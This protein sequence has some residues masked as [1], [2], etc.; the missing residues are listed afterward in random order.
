MPSVVDGDKVMHP[1]ESRMSGRRCWLVALAMTWLTAAL[2]EA[3]PPSN[4]TTPPSTAAPPTQGNEDEFSTRDSTVGYIDSAIPMDMFRLRF[5]AAY[6]DNHP[7]R[8]E[9][10][11]AKTGPNG[12][13]LP[14]PERD[15]DYQE[16]QFYIEKKILPNLSLFA[17]VPIRFLNPEINSDHWGLSDVDAGGKWAFVS[18]EDLVTTLQMR[19]YAPTGDAGR[20]LGNDHVTLE[21]ALLLWWRLDERWG[22]EG[23]LR[24]WAPIGG[25][26]FAGD[27]VRYGVGVHYDLLRSPSWRMTPVVELVGWTVLSGKQSVLESG[28]TAVV[29]SASGDTIVNLKVGVRVGISER[30]D[31]YAGYGR[32]LT[33]DHWYSNDVRVEW[34]W[35]Y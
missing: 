10:F 21:P 20:G 8:A 32:A 6:D 22:I 18:R 9:F 14:K 12:P 16:L 17:D 25:T 4:P 7:N 35:M 26:D 27:V 5:D 28:G 1:Q 3:Q 19:V 13:G 2:A 11:Y 15:V 23:E 30:S 33:G 29:T 34:R 31:L 24:Y